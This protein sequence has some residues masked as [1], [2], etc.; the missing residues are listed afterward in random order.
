MEKTMRNDIYLAVK[1][2][3]HNACGFGRPSLKELVKD[4]VKDIVMDEL[5]RYVATRDFRNM[6]KFDEYYIQD[7]VKKAVLESLSRNYDIGL[8]VKPKTLKSVK[9]PKDGTYEG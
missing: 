8:V 7:V 1:N 5:A 9:E 4:C 2:Y 6:I 3:I